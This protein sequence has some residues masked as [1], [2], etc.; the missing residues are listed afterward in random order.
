MFG[1]VSCKCGLQLQA[2]YCFVHPIEGYVMY[3][4][5]LDRGRCDSFFYSHRQTCELPIER[6][7]IYPSNSVMWIC[8]VY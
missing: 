8:N 6:Y 3:L 1:E 7:V 5:G 4:D 2:C